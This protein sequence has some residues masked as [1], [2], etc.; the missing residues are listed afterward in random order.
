MSMTER[1][2]AAARHLMM[3]HQGDDQMIIKC[4]KC[5]ELVVC[6]RDIS[7]KT[8]YD[9]LISLIEMYITFTENQD[10]IWKHLSKANILAQQLGSAQR[11]QVYYFQAAFLIS[12]NQF[13]QARKIIDRAISESG[14]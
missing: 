10:M 13:S 11:S 12:N 5:L 8:T 7:P 14:M 1:L 4:I 2:L 6:A 3:I 9:A